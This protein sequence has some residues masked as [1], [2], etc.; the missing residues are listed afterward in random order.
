[1]TAFANPSREALARKIIELA[2][3]GERDRERLCE[4]ALKDLPAVFHTTRAGF[5][6]LLGRCRRS[7][8][9]SRSSE[10]LFNRALT[11]REK[12]LGANHRNGGL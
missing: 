11:I 9:V 7:C 1:M 12:A 3:A 8:E 10:A 5:A 4:D 2:R 6:R